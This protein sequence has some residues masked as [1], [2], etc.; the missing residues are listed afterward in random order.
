[1]VLFST[2]EDIYDRV[3]KSDTRPLMRVENPLSRIREL[4]KAR[5]PY[6]M[7]SGIA[8]AA[9]KNIKDTVEHVER[10]YRTQSRSFRRENKTLLRS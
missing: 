5:T 4:L 6:Y 1:M 8:I 3:S 10:I 9:D 7:K 2:P